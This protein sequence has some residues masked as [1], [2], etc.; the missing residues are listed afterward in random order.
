M[1]ATPAWMVTLG[2]SLQLTSN[3]Q[4]WNCELPSG[5]AS[6]RTSVP[7]GKNTLLHG[8]DV[9]VGVKVQFTPAG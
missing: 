5:R 3:S 6:S 4:P 9:V 1:W 8:P 7:I 2:A